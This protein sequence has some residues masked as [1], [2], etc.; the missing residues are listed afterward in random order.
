MGFEMPETGY[1]ASQLLWGE[2]GL[3]FFTSEQPVAFGLGR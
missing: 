2:R 3:V 1:I